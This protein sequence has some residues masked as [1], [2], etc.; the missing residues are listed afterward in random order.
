MTAPNESYS[1]SSLAALRELNN[2][3]GTKMS[4][5]QGEI[6]LESFVAKGWLYKSEY[7]FF[8]SVLRSLSYPDLY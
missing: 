6:V 3:E 4:K 7:V 8:F 5:S 2:L 1:V